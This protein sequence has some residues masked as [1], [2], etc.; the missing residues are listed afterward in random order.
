MTLKL[1]RTPG[2][3]LVGFMG[4]GK[5]TVGRVL[6]EELGWSFSDIDQEIEKQEGRT[7]AEIFTTSGEPVFRSIEAEAVRRRVVEIE[8]GHP[9]VVALGG[10]AML[11][12]QTRDAIIN[13]GVT[14]WLQ[15]SLDRIRQRVLRDVTRPLA[16]SEETLQRLFEVRL[17]IYQKSDFSIDADCD[18][19]SQVVSRILSLPIF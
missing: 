5:S 1:K 7:I 13:S 16:A 9:C 17:P 10:G 4:S 11:L 8:A 2:L 19:P 6:A 12:Q 3:Y 18:D 15:C 14:V